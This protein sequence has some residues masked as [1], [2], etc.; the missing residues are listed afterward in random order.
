MLQITERRLAIR[1]LQP[2][3]RVRHF[4]AYFDPAS[5]QTA[6]RPATGRIGFSKPTAISRMLGIVCILGALLGGP[7]AARD[8]RGGPQMGFGSHPR[9]FPHPG[10]VPRPGFV[11]HRAFFPGRAFDNR[12]FLFG[13]VFVAP[14][15]LV[16]P[17]PV[18]PYYPYYYSPYPYPPYP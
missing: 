7:A 12:R 3:R 6:V 15:I 8:F 10:F 1:I 4:A 9:F 14:P 11:P 2:W 5:R 13:G 16:P 17:Y 18:Y